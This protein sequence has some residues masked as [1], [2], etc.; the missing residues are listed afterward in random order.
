[1]EDKQLASAVQKIFLA[2]TRRGR[3]FKATVFWITLFVMFVV[4]LGPLV[5]YYM[6]RH[7]NRIAMEDAA[8]RIAPAEQ[9]TAPE[10]EAAPPAG[11]AEQV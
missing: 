11:V 1:M 4:P 9:T 7:G 6:W 2:R 5:L 3:I 10:Q 8:D